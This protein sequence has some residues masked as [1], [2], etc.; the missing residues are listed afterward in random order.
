MFAAIAKESNLL[1]EARH[2][3]YNVPGGRCEKCQGAGKLLVS[4]NFLPDVE[5]VCPV[6]CGRRYQ[7]SV[8][9]VKYKNQCISD[10][11]DLSVDE[12]AALLENEHSIMEK[13]TILQDVGLG[14]LSLG[15]STSTLSGGEAQRLKLAKE[16]AKSGT[17]KVLYLFDEPTVGLH[18]QNVERLIGV[19][20]RLVQ[21]GNSVIVIEHNLRVLLAAD[22]II[23]LG[24]EGGNRG[25]NLI[26]AGTPKHVMEKKASATGKAL[27]D[28]LSE[29]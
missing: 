8:L 5:V 26:A 21:K 16:L 11:L 13:L 17:G 1:L 3:S 25:G 24:P 29:S 15:Q 12:A 27:C 20:D 23:D 19:F 4:M 28:Y 10:I 18:P 14:Y 2:F 9:N 7:K 6:C 22:W